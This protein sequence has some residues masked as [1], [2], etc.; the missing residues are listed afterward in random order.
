MSLFL[1][2]QEVIF[3][4]VIIFLYILII[5]TYLGLYTAAPKYIEN[6]NYFIKLY[7][8]LF[9]IFRFNP[10]RNNIKFSDFD[11]KIVFTSGIIILTSSIGEYIN[12]TNLLIKIYSTPFF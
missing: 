11:R 4:I 7:I 8:S 10:L 1:K 9:L 6:I 5:I 2:M 3:T 12:I